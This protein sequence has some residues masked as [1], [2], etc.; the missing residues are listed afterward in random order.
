MDGRSYGNK[1]QCQ[2]YICSTLDAYQVSI[3][4]E[5][6]LFANQLS[7]YVSASMFVLSWSVASCG[8]RCRL[9]DGLYVCLYRSGTWM[10]TGNGVMHNGTAVLD[11]YGH[12]LDRLKVCTAAVHSPHTTT[13]AAT[14]VTQSPHT[15]ATHRHNLDRLNVCTTTLHTQTVCPR[16]SSQP[17]YH[18]MLHPDRL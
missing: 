16:R 5:Y 7:V 3:G 17:T 14:P 13:T 18:S 1:I 10:M 11:D 8:H 15:T 6:R 12:N 4:D 9:G 2:K